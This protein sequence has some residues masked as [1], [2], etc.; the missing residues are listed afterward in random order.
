MRVSA[1]IQE[2]H[3]WHSK[4]QNG[5]MESDENPRV[6]SGVELQRHYLVAVVVLNNIPIPG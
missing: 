1:V 3:V 5:Y 4:H 6:K 2:F